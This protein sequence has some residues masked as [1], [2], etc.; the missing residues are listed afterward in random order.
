MLELD[1]A[2]RPRLSSRRRFARP[3]PPSREARRRAGGAGARDRRA[4]QREVDA[5]EAPASRSGVARE[6]RE[7]KRERCV[8]LRLVLSRPPEFERKFHRLLRCGKAI[9]GPH[10]LDDRVRRELGGA[11]R[12]EAL[13]HAHRDDRADQRVARERRAAVGRRVERAFARRAQAPRPRAAPPPARRD[14][15]QR[16]ARVRDSLSEPLR[17]RARRRAIDSA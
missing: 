9:E 6:P 15:R 7:R 4:E 16:R 14:S 12:R 11:A 10:G 1:E 2:K 8:E 17:E 13:G 5:L 3:L